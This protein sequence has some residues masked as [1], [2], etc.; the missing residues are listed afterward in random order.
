MKRFLSSLILAG[1][2]FSATSFSLLPQQY[3]EFAQAQTLD[4]LFYTFYG[5]KIPLHLRRDTV[6]VSFKANT[7]SR[8][9]QPLYLQ[10]QQDLRR[11]GSGNTRSINSNHHSVD[12]DVKPLGENIALVNL[13]SGTRASLNTVQQQIQKQ[14][15]VKEILPILSGKSQAASKEKESEQVIVLPNEI[16]ISFEGEMSE[17]QRQ[18]ILLRHDLEVLRPLRFSKNRYLVRSKS[19]S[20][21]EILSVANQL[22]Q[23][24]GV[25]SA[26]PNFIQTTSDQMSQ[27]LA[28]VANLPETPHAAERLQ[29]QL[30]QLPQPKDTPISSNLLPL[31]WHLN[32]TPRRG[33]LLARTDIRATEA[34]NKSN[35]GR[36]V[37][38]AVIDSL[39][40]WDH[41]DLVKNTYKSGDRPD[42]L[43]GEE[44]GWDF[45]SQGEGDP[46]T[47]LNSQ[48]LAQIQAEFQDTFKLP[49]DQLLKKY[50]QLSDTLKQRYPKASASEIAHRIRN[51][52]QTEIGSE[53]HGT[54][55]AGIIAANSEDKAGILGVAPDTQILPVR[56]FGLRGAINT[57]SLS[58]AIGYAASRNVD[59]I[60]MSLGGLLP[61]EGLTEQIFDV[62]DANRNLVIVASAGNENLDGVGF[63]AGIPGV[64]S[65]GATNL[66]GNRTFYSSYGGGLDLVAPGGELQNSLS[67]G[68]LTTGGTWLDGFWQGMPVPDYAWGLALDPLGKYVQVQG[69]SFSAPIVSGVVAL[70]KG[71]DPKRRLSREE[72]VSIL[73]KTA[74]YDG[75]KLSK[76]DANRYR[77]QK[78]VGFGTVV[79]APVS[80]P[81]GIFPKAKPVS[82]LEYFFGRG[83]VN[84]DAAVQAVRQK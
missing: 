19:V 49:S 48:E 82:A 74:T 72:I 13:P 4:E 10:L 38:V 70:M 63:P 43:P 79:D 31:Q 59:V 21:T 51:L 39:I 69:T 22:T 83:L 58:E 66:T 62:L 14:P 27:L 20:G 5:Q 47:R 24:A 40:Q 1:C 65:V 60:N 36:G 76:A 81:S 9:I 61:D 64:V 29:Q 37:V 68:I 26:T 57:A 17:S 67:G 16:V 28:T 11:G 2:F 71:E 50:Q 7:R 6:A 73:N 42:K 78:E 25:Q 80:R 32:S 75:L 15:Y 41:P 30:A 45:S 35:G 53:F 33:Q 8:S 54:W 18:I 34:W 56:V 46:D 84:A 52:I 23:V 44:Y 3:R 55:A 77:L 12:V